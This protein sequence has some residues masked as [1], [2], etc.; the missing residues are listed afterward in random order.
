MARTLNRTLIVDDKNH[1]L[2]SRCITHLYLRS[3]NIY[4]IR[5]NFIFSFL[6]ASIPTTAVR[7]L[8]FMWL[9]NFTACKTC[10]FSINLSI[11][12]VRG[13][14]PQHIAYLFDLIR[15]FSFILIVRCINKLDTR[16]RCAC[17][18]ASAP[19]KEREVRIFSVWISFKF[20]MHEF[21]LSFESG[22]NIFCSLNLFRHNIRF[23][24]KNNAL[25]FRNS[26][27]KYRMSSTPYWQLLPFQSINERTK[28][29]QIDLLECDN[30]QK[31]LI[32][33]CT[34]ED[35]Q[36]AGILKNTHENGTTTPTIL[37]PSCFCCWSM[38]DAKMNIRQ[39]S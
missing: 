28:W 6:F 16:R 30:F 1:F 8:T 31:T 29:N 22:L 11:H 12:V 37:S 21:R 2:L 13:S 25:Q 36:L 20:H 35:S 23:Q 7:T 14:T 10:C 15:Q 18:R 5:F 27:G 4:V 38:S 19:E 33:F 3:R 26:H 32:K 39:K 24:N 17:E 34:L 9:D